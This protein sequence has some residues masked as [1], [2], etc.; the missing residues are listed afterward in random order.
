[1]KAKVEIGV[2][3]LHTKEQQRWPADHRKLGESSSGFSHAA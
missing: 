3:L 2:M 1:M